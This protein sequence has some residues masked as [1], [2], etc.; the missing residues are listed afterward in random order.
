[1]SAG[2]REPIVR[3]RGVSKSYGATR[4]LDRLDLDVAEGEKLAIIGPSGSGKSTILRLL[5]GLEGFEAGAIEVA[6][7]PVGTEAADA[8]GARWWRPGQRL[9][10]QHL[11]G[12]VFQHF[13]LFP[14]MSAIHNVME[15]PIRVLGLSRRQA[16]QRAD[17]L[18]VLVRLQGK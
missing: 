15:A 10:K 11:V 16:R 5:M 14:H 6:G 18:F 1:M 4:V 3:F 2:M 13:N 8:R 7:Q 12:M 17:E 9:R